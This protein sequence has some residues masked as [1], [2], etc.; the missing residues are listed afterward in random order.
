MKK[1]EQFQSS[2]IC[3]ICKELT[4]NDDEKVKDHCHITRS[5]CNINLQLREKI[6]VI[7][8]N[9]KGYYSHL[10]FWSLTVLCEN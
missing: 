8:H 10:I 1:E 5:S 9:L 2:N 6:F 3:W 4:D 7:F